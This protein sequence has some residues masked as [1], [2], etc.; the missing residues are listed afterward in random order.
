MASRHTP[1]PPPA[2]EQTLRAYLGEHERTNDMDSNL[3]DK[4]AEALSDEGYR[5]RNFKALTPNSKQLAQTSVQ[6]LLT[7]ADSSV[8]LKMG[9]WL[10]VQ[11]ALFSTAGE[12]WAA[13][14]LSNCSELCLSKQLATQIYT[15]TF[16]LKQGWRLNCATNNL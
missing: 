5:L 1:A 15:S 2:E 12:G 10:S 6:E 9:H 8:K 13:K 4:V 3:L 11:Q 16:A 14:A 7:G